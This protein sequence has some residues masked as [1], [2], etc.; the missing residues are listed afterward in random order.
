MTAGALPAPELWRRRGR[1]GCRGRRRRRS[2][3][4]CLRRC[5]GVERVG[6]DDD[7]FELGRALAA[8]DAADQ[9]D[10]VRRW[11]SSCRSAACLRRRALRR[12]GGLAQGL[13]G[14]ELAAARAG[15]RRGRGSGRGLRR[16]RCRM[17]SAGCGSWTVW[18]AVRRDEAT[19]SRP[20]TKTA[21]R[22]D[23][24]GRERRRQQRDLCDPAFGAA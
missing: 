8:G 18:R 9:P 2:C 7:F 3:V 4:R 10:A 5:L 15:W 13:G 1:R 24:A 21:R 19:V 6:L 14:G 20:A 16:C 17:R 12:W 22:P 23:G 11:M